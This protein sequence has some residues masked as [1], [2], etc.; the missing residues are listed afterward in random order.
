MTKWQNDKKKTNGKQHKW[1][2]DKTPKWQNDKVNIARKHLEQK[3]QNNNKKTKWHKKHNDKMTKHQNYHWAE[4]HWAK[5]KK[6]N[7]KTTKCQ[8]DKVVIER[9]HLEQKKQ[10]NNQWHKQPNEKTTKLPLSGKAFSKEKKN[11]ARKRQND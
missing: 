4:V 6:Q 5:K 11:K 1:Q 9:K 7:D 10:K 3:K 2:N 8:N